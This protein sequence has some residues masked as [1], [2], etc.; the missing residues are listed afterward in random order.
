LKS[1]TEPIYCTIEEKNQFNVSR[2]GWVSK[3]GN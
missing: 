1:H 3:H 2:D